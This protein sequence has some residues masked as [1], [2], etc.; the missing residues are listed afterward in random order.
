M[1]FASAGHALTA[2]VTTGISPRSTF[3]DSNTVIRRV[4]GDGGR[5]GAGTPRNR[6]AGG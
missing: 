3:P 2:I 5:G 4:G 6:S 1:D